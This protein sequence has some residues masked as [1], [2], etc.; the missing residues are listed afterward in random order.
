M[1]EYAQPG[2][3]TAP[4]SPGLVRALLDETDERTSGLDYQ[5]VIPWPALRRSLTLLG[6]TLMPV[7]LVCSSGP[8]CARPH[9]GRCFFEQSY[10][11]LKVEP[12]DTT[13]HAGDN[14]DVAV[15]LAGRPVRTARWLYRK[16]GDPG[17]WTSADLA[18]QDRQGVR[19]RGAR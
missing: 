4:A 6:L 14:L 9:C 18:P 3:E 5:R 17:D 13:V 11:T 15:T 8:I 12:G 19:G 1:V 2:P 16:A 10:T 7:I